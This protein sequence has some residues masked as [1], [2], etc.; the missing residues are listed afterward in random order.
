[1]EACLWLQAGS[2][3]PLV[4]GF[5]GAASKQGF[6]TNVVNLCISVGV[7]F[8][9]ND[10]ISLGKQHATGTVSDS[11]RRDVMSARASC[12][13][14]EIRICFVQK[15]GLTGRTTCHQT[16]PWLGWGK[17]FLCFV[18][19][20]VVFSLCAHKLVRLQCVDAHLSVKSSTSHDHGMI[21]PR[22]HPGAPACRLTGVGCKSCLT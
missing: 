21:Y 14:R 7:V 15:R 19:C 10:S 2:S 8:S 9:G 6:D 11:A 18:F 4:R 3:G 1:M 20:V 16:G 5:A 22:A 17:C 13:S 12:L